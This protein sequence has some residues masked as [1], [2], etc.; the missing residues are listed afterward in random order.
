M[1]IFCFLAG[2]HGSVLLSSVV[3]GCYAPKRNF[4]SKVKRVFPIAQRRESHVLIPIPQEVAPRSAEK[5]QMLT[6]VEVWLNP[7]D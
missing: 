7:S 2:S 6:V 4:Q 5:K 3:E 1:N